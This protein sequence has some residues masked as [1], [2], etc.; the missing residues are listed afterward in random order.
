MN[1][2]KAK[3]PIE[4]T[5]LNEG[6]DEPEENEKGKKVFLSYI[7]IEGTLMNLYGIER[8]DKV[9]KVDMS[10][11][12]QKVVTKY[13]LIINKGMSASIRYPVTDLEFWYNNENIRDVKYDVIRSSLE[14]LKANIVKTNNKI[15]EDSY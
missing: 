8:I 4:L 2:D 12:T 3:K 9:F 14:A 1:K 6:R 11:N 5:D 10:A 13:G 7:E 15:T